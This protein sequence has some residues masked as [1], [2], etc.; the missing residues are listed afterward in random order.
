M[1]IK[2]YVLF[3]IDCIIYS[4]GLKYYNPHQT[5]SYGNIINEIIND[6]SHKRTDGI[7]INLEQY[8]ETSDKGR[9]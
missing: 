5:L 1:G 8:I 4:L 2:R 3:I 9:T 6:M 7:P